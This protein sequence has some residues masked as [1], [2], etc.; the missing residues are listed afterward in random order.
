MGLRHLAP[1]LGTDVDHA[2]GHGRG[3]ALGWVAAVAG[4]GHGHAGPG[5]Q[6]TMRG[7]LGRAGDLQGILPP[8]RERVGVCPR[9]Q[10]R[11]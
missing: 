4:A 5:A 10:Q 3:H 8:Q 2:H 1:Q 7:V 9:T 6:Q 11:F